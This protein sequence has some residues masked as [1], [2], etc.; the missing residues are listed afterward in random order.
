[1]YVWECTTGVIL[2]KTVLSILDFIK[3]FINFRLICNQLN[4]KVFFSDKQNVL[5][6]WST[7]QIYFDYDSKQY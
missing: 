1:M 6:I 2:S 4:L 3:D 7:M 5:I